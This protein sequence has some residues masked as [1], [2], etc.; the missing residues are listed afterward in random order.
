MLNNFTF[1][2][3]TKWGTSHCVW[4]MVNME[5]HLSIKPIAVEPE[6]EWFIIAEILHHRYQFGPNQQCLVRWEGF[7]SSHDSWVPRKDITPKALEAYELFLRDL[8]KYARTPKE[9]A[10]RQAELIKFIG[11]DSTFLH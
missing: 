2:I 1:R 11:K 7:D 3:R 4:Y 10:N 6:G 5:D 9:K 8:V